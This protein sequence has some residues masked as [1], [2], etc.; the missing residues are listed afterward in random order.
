[1]KAIA[2]ISGGLDSILAAQIVKEQG[3]D[4][5]PLNF[6][7]PF[8]HRAKKLSPPDKDDTSRAV[9]NLGLELKIIDIR[10]EFLKLLENP[11]HGFGA[12]MNPC[13]D[14]K[15]LMLAK[16]KELMKPLDAAFVLTGEVLGQRPMSQ[17]RQALE[18]I[19]K[20][21]GLQGLVLR[22]LSAKL[23][24]QTLPEKEGWV[25]RNKLLDFSGRT[26]RPQM[27][28][29]KDLNIKDY[30]NAAGGCLLTDPEFAKRLK[31]LINHQE[32]SM[33]NVELL[34]IGRHFRISQDAKLV[35]GRDEEEDKELEKLAR[36][37]DYLF[38]PHEELAGPTS[39]GR[40]K[41][42]KELVELSCQVTC[43]YSDLNGATSTDIVYKRVSEGKDKVLKVSPIGDNELICFRI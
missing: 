2:L 41:F 22:P 20:K 31:D 5:I 17:H 28:L 13:I 30:P 8:Y 10:N 35:V 16:A 7:V 18:I 1:M 21:S 3:I 33:D 24:T 19:E 15:I 34:K 12:N 29:A 4:I 9:D 23:L 25:D 14:C 6:K 27:E 36:E 42:S 43:R 11:Q 40:G 32:L 37:N 38:Y 26:R 39:L